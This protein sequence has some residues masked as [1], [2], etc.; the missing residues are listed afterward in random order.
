MLLRKEICTAVRRVSS[1]PRL[2]LDVL[3]N[4]NILVNVVQAISFFKFFEQDGYFD[5]IGGIACQEFDASLTNEAA[6]SI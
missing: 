4:V 3:H 5:T 6:R 2:L 1:K